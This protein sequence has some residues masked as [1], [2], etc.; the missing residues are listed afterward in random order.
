[1]DADLNLG[2]VPYRTHTH[3]SL[4]RARRARNDADE[5][6]LTFFTCCTT[7]MR[8]RRIELIKLG[9]SRRPAAESSYVHVL[10]NACKNT[11]I[12]YGTTS[13]PSPPPFV[14]VVRKDGANRKKESCA[15][16]A[17]LSVVFFLPCRAFTYR[18]AWVIS[19]V[20]PFSYG[21]KAAQRAIYSFI[22]IH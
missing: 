2:Q 4:R 20:S 7:R 19:Q 21:T 8:M 5:R 1:M 9:R 6:L 17:P 3:T 13:S 12:T 22:H 14:V 18:L 16:E 15:A 11:H 10:S